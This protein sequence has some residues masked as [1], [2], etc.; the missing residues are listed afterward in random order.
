MN[1]IGPLPLREKR[2][3][4]ARRESIP[5]EDRRSMLEG[6]QALSRVAEMEQADLQWAQSV[7]R[8]LYGEGDDSNRRFNRWLEEVQANNI[9]RAP[10]REHAALVARTNSPTRRY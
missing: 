9:R 6:L 4:Q 1:E 7:F 8:R 3:E 5:D 10:V 2:A